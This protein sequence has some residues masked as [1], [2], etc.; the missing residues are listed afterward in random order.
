M[1]LDARDALY[2][3]ASHVVQCCDLV[4]EKK[5]ALQSLHV[6]AAVDLFV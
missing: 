4:F 3:P 6:V 1:Q 5:P 2:L